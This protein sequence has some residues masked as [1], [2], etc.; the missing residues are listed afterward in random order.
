MLL[1]IKLF[2]IYYFL[3]KLPYIFYF[4]L[5]P[6]GI[7]AAVPALELFISLFGALCLSALGLAFPA[8]IQSCTYWYYVSRS[9]RIRMIVKNAIVV[10]FGVLGL[11]VGTWT[12]LERIIEKFSGAGIEQAAA[13]Q[14]MVQNTTLSP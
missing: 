9:E 4:V 5:F 3:Y 10:L 6:V 7:A 12:S 1:L 8:L 2:E 13:N 11:V 14:T